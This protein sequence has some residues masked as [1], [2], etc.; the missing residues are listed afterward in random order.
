MAVDAVAAA[1]EVVAVEDD[2]KK[3]SIDRNQRLIGKTDVL[4]G[5]AG[6]RPV[7]GISG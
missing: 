2:E 1:D 3:S 5:W 4:G 7:R 6:N